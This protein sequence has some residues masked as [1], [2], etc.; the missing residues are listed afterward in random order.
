MVE[1]DKGSFEE[2]L[3]S[4]QARQEASAPKPAIS[5]NGSPSP[6]GVGV[7]VGVELVSALAVGLA[8]GWGLDWLLGTKPWMLALFV[9]LGGAAGVANVWRLMLPHKTRHTPGS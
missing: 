4:A 8:I 2:R 6:M 5:S 9:L 3:R 7:R 1:P